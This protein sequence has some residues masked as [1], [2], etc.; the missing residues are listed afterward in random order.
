MGFYFNGT[1]WLRSTVK[2]Y[3]FAAVCT[4]MRVPNYTSRK[5]QLSL[6]IIIYYSLVFPQGCL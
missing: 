5:S 4:Y 1:H 2:I 6:G 3:D